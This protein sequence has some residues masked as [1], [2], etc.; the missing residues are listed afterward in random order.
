TFFRTIYLID[1]NSVHIAFNKP[2]LFTYFPTSDIKQT[3]SFHTQLYSSFIP[4]YFSEFFLS[5]IPR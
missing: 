1:L 2:F 4:H 5:Q 3:M